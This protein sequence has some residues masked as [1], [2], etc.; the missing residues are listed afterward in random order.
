ME[1]EA[2]AAAIFKPEDVER[3]EEE[4]LRPELGVYWEAWHALRYDRQYG[5][6]GGEFPITY[7]T[8]RGYANDY[9]I[10]GR[11]FDIFE[12]LVKQM[13]Y[14]HLEIVSEKYKEDEAKRKAESGH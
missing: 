6:M 2:D 9:G 5:A 12:H 3:T 14:V 11:A 4:E 13:D 8:L 7:G 10:A 1:E